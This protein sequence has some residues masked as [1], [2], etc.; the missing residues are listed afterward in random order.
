MADFKK[1]SFLMDKSSKTVLKQLFG[2]EEDPNILSIDA[3]EVSEKLQ[4]YKTA[5]H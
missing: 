5:K 4:E 1:Y 3:Q 2:E